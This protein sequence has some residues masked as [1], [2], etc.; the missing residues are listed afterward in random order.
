MRGGVGKIEGGKE[1]GLREE[2]GGAEIS[3]SHSTELLGYGG[4][5]GCGGPPGGVR[6]MDG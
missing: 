1:S 2:E 5:G 4:E 3:G 6:V